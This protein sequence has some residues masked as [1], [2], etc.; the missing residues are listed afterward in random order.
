MARLLDLRHVISPAVRD[1]VELANLGDLDRVVEQVRAMRG[2]A[3]PVN[4][5]GWTV[6]TG[7]HH[8]HDRPLLHHR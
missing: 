5:R 6:T 8:R 3:R 1:L 2:C 7:H 4:L